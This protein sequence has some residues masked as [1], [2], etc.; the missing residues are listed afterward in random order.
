MNAKDN[1]GEFVLPKSECETGMN[2]MEIEVTRVSKYFR[3][4]KYIREKP[5]LG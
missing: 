2:I 1:D 3:R 5:V 4:K